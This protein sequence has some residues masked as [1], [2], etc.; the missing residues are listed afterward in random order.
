MSLVLQSSGG[1]QIT[2]QEPATASNFT[3]TLP[4]SDG[5]I[6]TTT[7]PKVGNVLQVVS[8]TKTDTSATISSTFNDIAG[9]S[10]SITPTSSSSKIL[11]LYSIAGSN[12][13]G[14]G[15]ARLV[16][17]STA[18]SVGTE[19]TGNQINASLGNYYTYADLNSLLNGS[20]VFL[21]SPATTS[22]TTYKMQYR[23]GTGGTFVINR[24]YSNANQAFTVLTVSSITALEIAA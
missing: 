13:T 9:L 6:L 20:G 12:E 4:A 7:A 8:V 1:G 17:N 10:L 22:A 23:I 16:R 24:N 5:T 18:I 19:A 2:I 3:V 21:D 11:I 15:M 14:G